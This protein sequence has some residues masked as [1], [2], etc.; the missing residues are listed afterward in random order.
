M[1]MKTFSDQHGCIKIFIDS[2]VSSTSWVLVTVLSAKG[3]E[4]EPDPLPL[5]KPEWGIDSEGTM[6]IM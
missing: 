6:E 1:L 3:G 4:G 5:K 2:R